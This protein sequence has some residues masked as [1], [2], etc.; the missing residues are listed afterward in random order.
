MMQIYGTAILC[1]VGFT[2]SLFIDG[3]AYEHA[4]VGYGQSDRIAIIVGSLLCGLVGFAV[5]KMSPKK[6]T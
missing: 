5:L 1:G 2:M 4:G 3:L 6:G